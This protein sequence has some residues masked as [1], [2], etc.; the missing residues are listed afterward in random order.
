MTAAWLGRKLAPAVGSWAL[1]LLAATL[2]LRREEKAVEERRAAGAP[3]IYIVWHARLLLLPYLYRR[4]GLRVQ[5][6]RASC[7]ERV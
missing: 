6:G 4:R 7:R 3:L 1:R 2:R 5:I